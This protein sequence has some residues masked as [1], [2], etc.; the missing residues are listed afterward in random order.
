[1]GPLDLL[2][3]GDESP[4]EASR[5]TSG[6]R[7]VIAEDQAD[8]R[9]WLIDAL[10]K[11]RPSWTVSATATNPQEL[12]D[13]IEEHVP[14]L[15]ILDVHLVG[16]TSIEVLG[17]LPYPIPIVFTSGD[18]SFA[19]EAFEHAAVDYVLKPLRTTRL[20]RAL[21]RVEGVAPNPRES[22][23]RTADHE[24]WI[25]A[26]KSDGMLIIRLSEI[27]FLQARG[28]FTL[29]VTKLGEA[30]I[31]R[32]IGQVEQQLD[33]ARFVRIHRGTI[34]NFDYAGVVN[35]DDIGRMRIQMRNRTEWLD[36]SQTFEQV[37]KNHMAIGS[38]E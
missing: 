5:K 11:L 2:H 12:I 9:D 18:P 13:A 1:M 34:I 24:K 33:P 8:G 28:K 14:E 7:V 36:I 19:I 3:E 30:F 17:K 10:Q 25:V 26:H 6:K 27:V 37:F 4:V 23:G 35:R 22:S 32:G 16:G 29:V 15:L 38:P 20:E 21:R 31:K